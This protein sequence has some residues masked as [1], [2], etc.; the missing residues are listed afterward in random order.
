MRLSVAWSEQQK[1]ESHAPRY[2]RN[3]IRINTESGLR[4]YKELLSMNKGQVDLQN[5]VVWLPDW[6]T[7][8]GVAEISRLGRLDARRWARR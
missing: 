2:L 3:V 7:P 4:I 1:M 8:N 5:A 6:K